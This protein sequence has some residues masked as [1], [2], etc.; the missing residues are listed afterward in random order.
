MNCLALNRCRI[1]LSTEDTTVYEVSGK[2]INSA[3]PGCDLWRARTYETALELL[4]SWTFDLAVVDVAGGHATGLLGVLG[5]RTPPVPTVILSTYVPSLGSFEN[6]AKMGTWVY[7]P[8][9]SLE[10]LIPVCEN[11]L[12]RGRGPVQRHVR[13]WIRST[14]GQISVT[15]ARTPMTQ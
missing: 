12:G 2:A 5:S 3:A 7:L 11:L 8:R 6:L 4:Q 10:D 15:T 13:N 1:L 14:V 9:E